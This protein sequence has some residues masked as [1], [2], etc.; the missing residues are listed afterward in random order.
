MDRNKILELLKRLLKEKYDVD[1]D[2]LTGASRQ[3]EIGLD[4]MTM[5]DLMM[6]IETA[7]DIQFPDLNLPKNPSLDEIVDLIAKSSGP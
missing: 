1:P 2:S 3:D 5:V 7:L 6:D 4:S